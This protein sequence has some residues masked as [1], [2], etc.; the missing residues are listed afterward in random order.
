MIDGTVATPPDMWSRIRIDRRLD[1][2]ELRAA[3]TGHVPGAI[4]DV[5]NASELT[6]VSQAYKMFMSGF[7]CGLIKLSKRPVSAIASVKYYDDS[8]VLQTWAAANYST[9]IPNG[10]RAGWAYVVPGY[11]ISY[12][13]TYP[14]WDA[15]EVAFTAGWA[16][17]AI[18]EGVQDAIVAGVARALDK[19][20]DRI[21]D[22]AILAM[23][24]RPEA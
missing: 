7:P 16:A 13:T 9:I 17:A 12:P 20:D 14:R 8:N 19:H 6:V 18:P 5:E 15:V 2:E 3:A 4:V 23:R 22:P 10:P 1:G 11:G 24:Y 21:P